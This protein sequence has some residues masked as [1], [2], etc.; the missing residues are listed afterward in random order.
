[1]YVK[2]LRTK[3]ASETLVKLQQDVAHVNAT[4]N[5]KVVL[6]VYSDRGGELMNVQL[7][8]GDADNRIHFTTTES[9]DPAANGLADRLVGLIKQTARALLVASSLPTHFWPFAV[10]YAA[11]GTMV[12]AR[13]KAAYVLCDNGYVDTNSVVSERL[14]DIVKNGKESDT[15][16]QEDLVL[17]QEV[18]APEAQLVFDV[19]ELP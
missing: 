18:P 7:E 6:R 8:K 17:N 4:L 1:V 15:A 16:R 10:K 2:L 3:E 14:G 9:R 5:A 19:E 12:Y 13:L 11:L